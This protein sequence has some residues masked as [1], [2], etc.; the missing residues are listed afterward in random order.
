MIALGLIAF[1]FHTLRRTLCWRRMSESRL[2]RSAVNAASNS[3]I[4]NDDDLVRECFHFPHAMTENS[5]AAIVADIAY[6]GRTA[7]LLMISAAGHPS[8]WCSG[9]WSKA[10]QARPL[11]PVGIHGATIREF[12]HVQHL[13]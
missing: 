5:T 3:P 6:G 2:K 8:N 10:R 7:R 4:R 9:A 12:N 11:A 13:D 1:G